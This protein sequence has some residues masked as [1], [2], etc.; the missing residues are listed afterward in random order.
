MYSLIIEDKQTKLIK[1]FIKLMEELRT[2]R[3]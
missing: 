3:L 2:I 1:R